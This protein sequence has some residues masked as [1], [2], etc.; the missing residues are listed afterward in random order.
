MKIL[1]IN[2]VCGSGSTGKICEQIARDYAAKG[3]TV[4]IAYGRDDYPVSETSKPYAKFIG[5]GI[6]VKLHALMSR[7]FD[8]AGLNSKAVTKRF[9][10]WADEYKPDL[11]WLHNIHGYYINYKL[12]FEWIKSLHQVEIRWTLHDC[13]PFTGHCAYFSAAGCDKWK[14]GCGS[15]PQKCEYPKSVLADRSARNYQDKLKAF[16]GVN[17]MTLIVPSEWLADLVRQSFMGQYKVEV[18]PNVADASVFKPTETGFRQKYGLEGKV[19]LLGVATQW[20]KRKNLPDYI[21][22]ARRLGDKVTLVLLGL[23][24]EQINTLPTNVLGFKNVDSQTDLAGLYS[25]ADM[26]LHLSL[27]ETFGMTI[28]EA[29]MCGTKSICYKDTACEEV[30]L[31]L[32]G[33]VASDIEEVIN[34]IEREIL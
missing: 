21:E 12:L 26:L 22:V 3:H 1:I 31:K 17:N 2:E 23:T 13:W 8:N 19:I 16:T 34:T 30:A 15:C 20:N 6:D 28:L 10:R 32:G 11:I 33:F 18:V 4:T 24:E 29:S 14:T 27:E 7:V 9:I 5:S 25:T